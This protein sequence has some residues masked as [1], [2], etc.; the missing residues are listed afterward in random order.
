MVELP[1]CPPFASPKKV[2]LLVVR[3]FGCA[4]KNRRF[5]VGFSVIFFVF[6]LDGR[7]GKSKIGKKE[8]LIIKKKE[9]GVVGVET[10]IHKY[11]DAYVYLLICIYIYIYLF[12]TWKEGVF[13]KV[14]GNSENRMLRTFI[15]TITDWWYVITCSYLGNDNLGDCFSCWCVPGIIFSKKSSTGPTEQNPNKPEYLIDRSQ[16]T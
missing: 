13:M 14:R 5:S 16:F 6:G 11:I 1:T 3:R 10:N 8:K 7:V 4:M 2:K 12:W 9:F 15:L